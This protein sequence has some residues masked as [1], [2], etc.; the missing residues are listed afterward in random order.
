VHIR[1]GL[2]AFLLLTLSA[3]DS[4]LS[5]SP[6]DWA[7]YGARWQNIYGPAEFKVGHIGNL[8]GDKVAGLSVSITNHSGFESISVRSVILK[9][10]KGKYPAQ[11]RIS[12]IAPGQTSSGYFVW[13]FEKPIRA[14]FLEPMRV[15]IVLRLGQKDEMLNIPLERF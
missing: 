13:M 2:I 14:I 12:Q 5:Y 3:C 6:R 4:G 11:I 15:E 1:I 8:E 9:T 7:F 10:G